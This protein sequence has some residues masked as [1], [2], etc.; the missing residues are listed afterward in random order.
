MSRSRRALGGAVGR[1]RILKPGDYLGQQGERWGIARHVEQLGQRAVQVLAGL[2]EP[3]RL[4]VGLDEVLVGQVEPGRGDRA[5][6][7]LRGA[8]EVV[9]VVRVAGGAVGDDQGGL[10]GPVRRARL[11]GRSSPG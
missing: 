3:D 11:A 10:P 8:A 7:H 1:A 5:A 9:L 6:D 2:G 4:H